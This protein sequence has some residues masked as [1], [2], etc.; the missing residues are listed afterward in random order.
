[1][2]EDETAT[3]DDLQRD[4]F[5][6]DDFDRDEPT[7]DFIPEMLA[8]ALIV[9]D[10]G[11]VEEPTP[12]SVV[13]EWAFSDDE[14][15]FD[16]DD[17]LHERISS[18]PGLGEDAEGPSMTTL[19]PSAV[20][21]RPKQIERTSRE[22]WLLAAV[23]M[24]AV[25]AGV[26]LTTGNDGADEASA[27]VQ[28]R[29]EGVGAEAAAADADEPASLQGVVLRT[30][31][32]GVMATVEGKSWGPLPVSLSHL[33]PGTHRIRF[34]APGYHAVERDVLVR[35]GEMADL[36]VVLDPKP[37]QV[38]LE[39][40]PPN[41]FVL[42]SDSGNL[43][44]GRR[45]PGPWPRIIELEPGNYTFV[46]FRAGFGTLQRNVDIEPGPKASA[47]RFELPTEDV[48]E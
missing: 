27:A 4:D 46:A 37:V 16:D 34:E 17:E 5:D 44:D 45:F 15:R 22:P 36:D 40:E 6:R 8:H 24:L 18:M 41:A 13:D 12:T 33:S 26:W 38:V 42:L 47:V 28:D 3:T 1:M 32:D 31:A 20:T 29:S 14:H 23:A 35:A 30:S 11:V 9:P 2:A 43:G 10:P 25:G 19:R 39:V 21:L 48:Y 7:Q